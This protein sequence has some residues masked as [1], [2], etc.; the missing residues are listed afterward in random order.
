MDLHHHFGG[1]ADAQIRMNG[2]KLFFAS[3]GDPYRNG[4]VATL[5]ALGN[6]DTGLIKTRR[7]TLYHFKYKFVQ[8]IPGITENLDGILRAREFY[9]GGLLFGHSLSSIDWL[10]SCKQC[11]KYKI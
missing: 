11:V 7:M 2:T 5:A 8:L 4:L 9:F 10:R 3:G 6:S 1:W